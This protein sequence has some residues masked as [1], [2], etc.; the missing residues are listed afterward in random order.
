MYL[1]RESLLSLLHIFLRFAN[2]LVFDFTKGFLYHLNAPLFNT[3]SSGFTDAYFVTTLLIIRIVTFLILL[4]SNGI[5]SVGD[6]IY[7][8]LSFLLKREREYL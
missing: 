2:S 8:K 4:M 1:R 7:T 6:Y 3:H 5:L